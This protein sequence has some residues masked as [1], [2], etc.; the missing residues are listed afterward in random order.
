M[1]S[2][3]TSAAMLTLVALLI[4]AS[5]ALALAGSHPPGKLS[6]PHGDWPKGLLELVNSE[7]RVHGMW[8]NA[9]DFFYYRGDAAAF[10]RF[11]ARYGTVGDTPLKVIIRGGGI[12]RT[13]D[14][15]K[16][17]ETRFDWELQAV[18][19]GWGAPIDPRRPKDKQGYVVTVHLWTG[20]KIRL[21]QLDLPAHVE[22]ESAGEIE[23]FIRKHRQKRK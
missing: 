13:G 5:T 14:L 4:P 17:A 8:V 21:D 22:V 20:D 18:A 7:G 15:E 9:S 16:E 11:V 23:E 3:T 10:N 2:L 19:R 12:P 6:A 1:R